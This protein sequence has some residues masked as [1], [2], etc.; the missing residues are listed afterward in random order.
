MIKLESRLQFDILVEIMPQLRAAD[1]PLY[2][3]K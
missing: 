3:G 2:V 1:T